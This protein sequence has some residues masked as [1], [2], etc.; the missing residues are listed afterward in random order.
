MTRQFV[1]VSGVLVSHLEGE[2]VLL[3]MGTK[4]YY[5]L[6]RTGAYIW[7]SLERSGD[8]AVATDALVEAFDVQRAQADAA[9][10]ALIAELVANDLL[11]DTSGDP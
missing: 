5:R 10:H 6:N 1:P 2:A 9:V 8:A 4:Q 7:K 11:R 3:H